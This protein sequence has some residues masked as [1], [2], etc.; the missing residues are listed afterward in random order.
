MAKLVEGDGE[1]EKGGPGGS[2]LGLAVSKFLP[3]KDSVAWGEGQALFKAITDGD[4]ERMKE[5]INASPTA[6]QAAAIAR[7]ED[8]GMT[9]L[10]YSAD[11]GR[12][13]ITEVLLANGAMVMIPVCLVYTVSHTIL[14]HILKPLLSSLTR[15]TNTRRI[16]LITLLQNLLTHFTINT[17][18]TVNTLFKLFTLFSN[19]HIV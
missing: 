15:L 17:V 6:A 19:Q 8:T 18:N 1:E 4:I 12:A 13:D 11:R 14:Q 2:N 5:C 7:D 3:N 10:H 16:L 9:P